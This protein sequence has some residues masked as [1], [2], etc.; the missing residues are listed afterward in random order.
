M[1]QM[2]C[3]SIIDHVLQLKYLS[4]VQNWQGVFRNS[5]SPKDR[6]FYLKATSKEDLVN[7]QAFSD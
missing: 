7:Q 4:I 2:F 5:V 3:E 1:L 6:L